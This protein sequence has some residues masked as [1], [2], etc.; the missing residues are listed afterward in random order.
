MFT[1]VFLLTHCA[2]PPQTSRGAAAQPE[3]GSLLRGGSKA[4]AYQREDFEFELG[5]G[6]GGGGLN[7]AAAQLPAAGVASVAEEEGEGAGLL[8][9]GAVDSSGGVPE[10][11]TLT[12]R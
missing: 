6:G 7:R 9:A 5:G 8:G 12:R 10:A 11:S 1:G 3:A 2:A 4:A